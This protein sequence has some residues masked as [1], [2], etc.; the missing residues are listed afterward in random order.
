MTIPFLDIKSQYLSI[1]D[2]IDEAV[3]RVFR[4]G[5]F[6]GGD[7]VKSFERKFTEYH[8]IKHAITTGNGTDSLFAILKMLGVGPGDEVITP[9]WSWIST[10]ETVS[11]TG[12]VPIFVDADPNTFNISI[13]DVERKISLSTKVIMAVH[14]YGQCCNL[15]ALQNICTKHNL[16]L[17]EDCA[18]AHGAKRNNQLAGTFGL[19]SSF[20]F[21]PTK[22]LGAFG[23]AGCMLTNDD[24]LA[25]KLRRFANHGG[26]AKDEHV[27]EGMNSRMDSIQAAILQ[28]KLEYLTGWNEKRI[29]I[30]NRYHERLSEIKSIKLPLKDAGNHHVFHLFVIRTP[31]RN[32]LKSFLE[33]KGIATLIHYPTALPFEP[34]YSRFNFREQDFPVAAILQKEV[35][36]LP[37][38]PEMTEEM[39]EFIC[40]CVKEF[41]Q[42]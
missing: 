40:A 15:E 31:K 5:K 24:A 25:I 34:A 33:S 26:L 27:M 32:E 7:E 35:L 41:S 11:A 12:A 19:A 8:G 22:N 36:S 28:V 4:S 39:V 37:C 13:P 14:L 20:S 2:Q 42:G 38:N 23:D 16:I 9:A 30:A 3:A 18:Q 1:K 10:S 17:M 29:A 21:Y 6:I